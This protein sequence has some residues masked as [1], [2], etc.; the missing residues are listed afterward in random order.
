MPRQ[1]SSIVMSSCYEMISKSWT[2]STRTCVPRLQGLGRLATEEVDWK[3]GR[4]DS[5]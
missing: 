1:S 4:L 2:A 3:M 5:P